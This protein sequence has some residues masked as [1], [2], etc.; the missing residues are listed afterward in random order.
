MGKKKKL[1]VVTC[2]M[3]WDQSPGMVNGSCPR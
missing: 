3:L 1:V 2:S